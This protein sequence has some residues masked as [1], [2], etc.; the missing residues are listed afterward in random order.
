MRTLFR[1][2]HFLTITNET[3]QI[4]R[5]LAVPRVE[6]IVSSSYY[7]SWSCICCILCQIKYRICNFLNQDCVYGCG[8]FTKITSCR[9]GAGFKSIFVST[10]FVRSIRSFTGD[11][12]IGI[13]NRAT[14]IKLPLFEWI[15]PQRPLALE[16]VLPV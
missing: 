1:A 7:R 6:G 8:L 5:T 3:K 12:F 10:I 14:V 16:T 4:S 13:G 11:A 15:I 2:R 9:Y